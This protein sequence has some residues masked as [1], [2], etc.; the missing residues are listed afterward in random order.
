MEARRLLRLDTLPLTKPN[1]AIHLAS[2][3]WHSVDTFHTYDRADLLK[4]DGMINCKDGKPLKI[5]RVPSRPP[6]LFDALTKKPEAPDAAI[7][8]DAPAL[9]QKNQPTE[10]ATG[11]SQAEQLSRFQETAE[12]LGCNPDEATFDK[13]LRRIAQ[14]P[15]KPRKE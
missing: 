13:A 3:L 6:T 1:D 4:L 2:A 9:D 7:P 5:C 14:A 12:K 15:H 8:K 11:L 10:G